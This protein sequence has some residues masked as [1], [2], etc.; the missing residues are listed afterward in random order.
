MEDFF[1]FGVGIEKKKME[2][3]FQIW[4]W[5]WKN[6]FEKF[7]SVGQESSRELSL[8]S[9]VN[10]LA[11]SQDSQE[12]LPGKFQADGYIFQGVLAIWKVNF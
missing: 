10:F 7:L 12:H 3:F 11:I 4:S 8:K 2:D 5:H 9:R 1:R 6:F